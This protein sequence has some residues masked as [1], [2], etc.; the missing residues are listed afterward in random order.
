MERD[1]DVSVILPAPGEKSSI[2]MGN[3]K[4]LTTVA[5]ITTDLSIGAKV[6]S[7]VCICIS[8]F[9]KIHQ[10]AFNYDLQLFSQASFY[11]LEFH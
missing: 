8:L 3:S 11:S 10:C 7:E 4:W 1:I 9:T 2:L 6:L 5:I